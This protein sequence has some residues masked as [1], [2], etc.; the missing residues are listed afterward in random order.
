[1]K[2][3]TAIALST[4]ALNMTGGAVADPIS[5]LYIDTPLCD[6]HGPLQAVEEF[7]NPSAFQ[8]SQWIEHSATFTD[9]VA[10]SATDDPTMPNA[11]VQITNLTNRTLDNLFYV[12]DP[13]TRFSNVDGNGFG[14]GTPDIAGLAF[15]IDSVGANQNLIF[16]SGAF[17]GLFEPGETWQFIVQDYENA[18]G[19]APDLFFS[20]GMA[21]DSI[22]IN[23]S[24]ASIVRMVP[25]PASASLIA[26]GGLAAAR[27]RR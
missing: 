22:A 21:G 20:V 10:C 19:T 27:R 18:I 16:E 25:T 23:N 13:E 26:L 15:R 6:N 12:G 11:L 7:G 1:M 5:G 24:S 17:N 2:A 4:L 3:L 14:G 8:P 9:E